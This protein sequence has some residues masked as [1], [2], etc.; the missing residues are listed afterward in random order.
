MEF[1]TGTSSLK[2][3][4]EELVGRN[5]ADLFGPEAAVRHRRYA[6]EAI[7]TG[8]VQII[9]YDVPLGEREIQVESRV[10]KSGDDEVVVN[11]R[12]I[13]KRVELEQ[14][15]IDAQE[16][17]RARLGQVLQSHRAQLQ[18]HHAALVA[19]ASP[20]DEES[21]VAAAR[22]ALDVAVRQLDELMGD[23]AALPEGT[24][25]VTALKT[26]ASRSE[27]ALGIRCRLTHGESVPEMP[28][29]TPDLYRFAQE[30]I[31][32]AVHRGRAKNVEMLC[33]TIN[34]QFVLSVVDDGEDNAWASDEDVGYG[35]R[36][37]RYLAKRLGGK[38]TRSRRGSRG[39][40]V[41]CSCPTGECISLT[42]R[43][44][45]LAPV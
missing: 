42:A 5:I 43:L 27:Q 32:C 15:I 34:N 37:M 36:I 4:P 3:K 39:T 1:E 7:R 17:E 29:Q 45:A 20:D 10:V 9:E 24:T 41:T 14:A 16:R 23:F 21:S 30:A 22:A 31:G 26:L 44:R 35:M 38:L 2:L 40:T 33:S 18:T 19:A 25:V 12:D 6:L 11:I 28:V 13:T 8:E